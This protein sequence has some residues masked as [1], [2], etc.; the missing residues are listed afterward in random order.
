M[1]KWEQEWQIVDDDGPA[2]VFADFP[3]MR[4]KIAAMPT[5]GTEETLWFV[6]DGLSIGVMLTKDDQGSAIV[7]LRQEEEV[8]LK[9]A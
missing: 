3:P 9:R 2:L 8:T 1:G 6:V 7:V 5:G 4:L